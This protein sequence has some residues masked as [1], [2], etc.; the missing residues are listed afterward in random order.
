MIPGLNDNSNRWLSAQQRLQSEFPGQISYNHAY[1]LNTLAGLGAQASTI[2][3]LTSG[4]DS[5]KTAVLAHSAGGVVARVTEKLPTRKFNGIVTVGTPHTGAPIA[6]NQNAATTWV[7]G[8][9]TAIM[10]PII[11][12][13]GTWHEFEAS[14]IGIEAAVA[15]ALFVVT[16]LWV[17]P[18]VGAGSAASNDL[19]TYSPYLSFTSATSVNDPANLARESSAIPNRYAIGVRAPSFSQLCILMAGI[20]SI[21]PWYNCH[22]GFQQ[23]ALLY[24]G[25]SETW[26][27]YYDEYDPNAW[28]KRDYA[29]LWAMGGVVL[30]LAN[31]TWCELIGAVPPV[32]GADGFIP[33]ASQQG[34]LAA[35]ASSPLPLQISHLVEPEDPDVQAEIVRLLR[36]GSFGLQ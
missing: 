6:D 34:W 30:E 20:Q 15:G 21:V 12:Y 8:G 4:L 28:A 5:T 16:K 14:L 23:L 1:G 33:L 27:N 17:E 36:L 31:Y 2:E 25:Q 7:V 22:D 11:L 19:K 24:Y 26:S 10:A 35:T 29:F 9:G 18:A 13:A 32:C 3:A